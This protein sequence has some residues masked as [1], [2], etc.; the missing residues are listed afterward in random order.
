MPRLT[1]LRR[2]CAVLLT[3]VVAACATAQPAPV[4]D[5]Q[6]IVALLNESAGA[7]N[8]GDLDGFLYP[9][10]NSPQTS[11]ITREVVRG[12]PAIRQ[13]YAETW[14]RGGRPAGDLAYSGIEV[15]PLGRDYALVVGHWRVTNRETQRAQNGIFSLTFMRSPQG[16]RIIHD[17]SS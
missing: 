10:L 7:W 16:W 17:H 8:R 5:E 12:V 2:A 3:A 9:Y 15:R 6:A 1:P 4:N 14:F 13:S 11:Y